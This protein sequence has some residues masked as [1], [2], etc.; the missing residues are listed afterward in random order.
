MSSI[1]GLV[2]HSDGFR[3]TTF[4]QQ[5]QLQELEVVLRSPLS[6]VSCAA[7]SEYN[8]GTIVG[9][10]RRAA[11][12]Y[13]NRA[14]LRYSGDELHHQ[15]LVEDALSLLGHIQVHQAPWPFFIIACE[16]HTD[17]QRRKVLRLFPEATSDKYLKRSTRGLKGMVHASWNQ[18]DL[19][20]T[21]GLDYITKVSAAISSSPFL[22]PFC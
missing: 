10:Y 9:L 16:A 2:L 18:D 8:L 17:I 12:L 14:A 7:E 6:N 22:P 19:H 3:A 1:C 21:E 5:R 15:R 4:E 11:L 20:A 13:L